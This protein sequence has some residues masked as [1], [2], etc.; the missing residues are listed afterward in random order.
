MYY[1]IIRSFTSHQE[2]Y[3]YL[4]CIPVTQKYLGSSSSKA[5]RGATAALFIHITK[6]LNCVL[7]LSIME[8]A[9]L[10]M[11]ISACMVNTQLSLFNFERLLE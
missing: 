4:F 11:L 2:E 3:I 5:V 10:A 1:S 6:W 7:N 9:S 8:A